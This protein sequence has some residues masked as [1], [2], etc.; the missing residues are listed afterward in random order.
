MIG[1]TNAQTIVQSGG[2]GSDMAH[3]HVTQTITG[4][5]CTL[6]LTTYNS[7]TNNNYW[8]GTTT[9][10][11]TQNL[12]MV[13]DGN[14]SSVAS[15]IYGVE[16]VNDDTTTMTRTDDAQNMA[17]A[18]S[19]GRI[20]SDFDN[21][22]PYN[23][24]RRTTIDGNVFVY[25]PAMYFRVS[26]DQDNKIIGVAVSENEGSSG[27]WYQT[28]EFYYGAYGASSDGTVLKSVSGANRENSIGRADS[29]TRAMAVGTGYHQRDLY[30]ST[31]LTFLW[32]IEFATKNSR[33]IMTGCSF[34]QATGGTDSFYNETEGANFC[35]S[36]YDTTTNQMVWHGIEDF[37]GNGN[38]WEDGVTG[39]GQTSNLGAY[40]NIYVSD[41]YTK[42]DE[43]DPDNGGSQMDLY[44]YKF[45]DTS[46]GQCI[47]SF[48]WDNNHPF[49]VLPLTS[50]Q[51]SNYLT[52]FC[53]EWTLTNNPGMLRG[54]RSPTTAGHGLTFFNASTAGFSSRMRCSSRLLK[55]A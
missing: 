53:S 55:N 47:L 26:R 40:G 43:Y 5:T 41:D 4:N 7:E 2:G 34:W 49:L 14:N 18:I 48:G 23:Q 8:V 29:R 12:F 51:D 30:S 24:M 33:S 3:Y 31:I 10:G 46:T 22:F 54:S 17:Y 13:G 39:D 28:R 25:V 20:A 19:N 42:Y 50:K 9:T 38:E 36:G 16:W 27:D 44:A 21:V 15:R 1:K 37:I 45:R 6:S 11:S 35:V 32:W 52:A